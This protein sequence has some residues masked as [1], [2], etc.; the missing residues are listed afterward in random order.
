MHIPVDE[1]FAHSHFRV[2]VIG[3]HQDEAFVL[4]QRYEASGEK[5]AAVLKVRLQQQEY[6]RAHQARRAAA[7]ALE[8]GEAGH[9][10][11]QHGA[12]Q[13]RPAAEEADVTTTHDTVVLESGDALERLGTLFHVADQPAWLK[14][15]VYA[16]DASL[17]APHSVC[18][19]P[20]V[21]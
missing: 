2:Q 14:V 12:D 4:P 3:R 11:Q 15:C 7:A 19:N 18:C 5:L 1:A 20:P 9:G 13:R 21:S 17:Q 16:P 8:G 6:V 10:E